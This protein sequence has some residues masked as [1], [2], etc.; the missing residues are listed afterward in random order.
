MLCYAVVLDVHAV[1]PV[2]L[3]FIYIRVIQDQHWKSSATVY[4]EKTIYYISYLLY[5][6]NLTNANSL[7]GKPNLSIH[8][9]K[10]RILCMLRLHRDTALATLYL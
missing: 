9:G 7:H 2:L 5:K 4:N 6:Q 1:Q 8:P 3:Q 10:V